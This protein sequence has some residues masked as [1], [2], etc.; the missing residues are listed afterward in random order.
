MMS[1][2]KPRNESEDMLE[3]QKHCW[4]TYLIR[5][6]YFFA[7]VLDLSKRVTLYRVNLVSR[8]Y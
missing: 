6:L 8:E 1:T 2:Q 3:L 7:L 4:M 5:L